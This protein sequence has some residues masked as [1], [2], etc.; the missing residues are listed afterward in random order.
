MSIENRLQEVGVINYLRLLVDRLHWNYCQTVPEM[1]EK[2]KNVPQ[3]DSLPPAVQIYMKSLHPKEQN[4]TRDSY[5]YRYALSFTVLSYSTSK[6]VLYLKDELKK[7]FGDYTNEKAASALAEFFVILSGPM[8]EKNEK[9]VRFF[10]NL[11]WGTEKEVVT[12][13]QRWQLGAID[14]THLKLAKVLHRL[15]SAPY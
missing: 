15:Q 1:M 9:N 13:L 3:L 5:L 7:E 2:L 10:N 12:A 8:H 4:K 14:K 6:A 11:N